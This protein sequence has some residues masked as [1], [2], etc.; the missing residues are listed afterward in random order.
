M[1]LTII[2]DTQIRLDVHGQQPLTMQGNTWGALPMLA[3]S[4]AVCT[5]AVLREYATTA[6]FTLEPFTIVVRWHMA[7]RPRRVDR[8]DL[9]LVLGPH[10]PPSR[11]DAL[12]RAAE[13]CPVHQT[14]AHGMEIDSAW[15]V[16]GAQQ[17]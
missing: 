2:N 11:H 17:A 1:Q 6:Q 15:E 14:L 5:T 7:E 4:L 16:Q 10:V 9:R 3:A 8:F 13:Q 12:V